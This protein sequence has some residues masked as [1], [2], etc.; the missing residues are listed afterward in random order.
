MITRDV[1]VSA[2]L[3]ERQKALESIISLRGSFVTP[4]EIMSIYDMDLE[5]AKRVAGV[6]NDLLLEIQRQLLSEI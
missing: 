2:G 1:Q 3:T 5:E 6:A 4:L